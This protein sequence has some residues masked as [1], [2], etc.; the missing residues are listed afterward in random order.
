MT[1]LRTLPRL[2]RSTPKQSTAVRFGSS[3][4]DHHHEHFG[5]EP[6]G[7]FLGAPGKD[8]KKGKYFWEPVWVWGYLGGT[9]V[10]LA[11]YAYSPNKTVTQVAK[12]EAHKRLAESGENFGWPFPPGFQQK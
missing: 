7:Y 10:F 4:S 8:G 1:L 3:H 12:I 6:T 11:A 9:A 5:G 2:V